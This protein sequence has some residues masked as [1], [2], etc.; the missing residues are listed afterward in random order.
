MKTLKI[1][2]L[3]IYAYLVLTTVFIKAIFFTTACHGIAEGDDGSSLRSL[4]KPENRRRRGF[5]KSVAKL[6]YHSAAT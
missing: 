6:I 2:V 1:L 3:P 4:R 5:C